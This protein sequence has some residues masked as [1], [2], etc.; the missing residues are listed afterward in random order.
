MQFPSYFHPQINSDIDRLIN[1]KP[2]PFLVLDLSVIEQRY[3]EMLKGFPLADIFYAVKANPA[4]EIIEMLADLGS[5]FDIASAQELEKVLRYKINPNR[6]AFGNTI[7]KKADIAYF[8]SRGV[9]LFATDCEADLNNIAQYAPGSKVYIRLLF[10][11]SSSADWPLSNK[12]GCQS[13]TAIKLIEKAK[14]LGL[15]P[16]G[17]SFHVGSQQRDIETWR[18]AI[19]ATKAIFD[20]VSNK[21]DIDLQMINL[22][23]G[24]PAKYIQQT[25][26]FD[27]YSESIQAFI[28][29]SFGEHLPRIIIEPGRSL[30]GD[31]GIIVSE[32]VL[33]VDKSLHSHQTNR[34]VYTDVGTFNGLIE[35]LGEAIKYPLVT[36]KQGDHDKVTLAGPTCDSLDIMYEEYQ[37][38][39]PI[40]LEIGDH[41]FW[42]S[43]G[44]YTTSYS[45]IEFNGF[46]PLAYYAV[47]GIEQIQNE[48]I[49]KAG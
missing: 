46:P 4:P 23:G 2:T 5:N 18:Q 9:R 34:W 16:Y 33:V 31:A 28:K 40:S 26:D 43:T 3:N 10:D 45:S 17:I 44:A 11:G 7:K 13:E 6:I 41:L 49:R 1:E 20:E 29:Q 47:G 24:L 12:F 15:K 19:L 32:V 14:Q 48:E 35:T 42:L 38:Q 37:Y 27:T 21:Y 22:G 30:V 39:L 36:R 8:Y 25:D